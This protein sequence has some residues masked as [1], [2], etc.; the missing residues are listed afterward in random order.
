MQNF[1]DIRE[2]LESTEYH[3]LKA[4]FE[5]LG[6]GDVFHGGTKKKTLIDKAIEALELKEEQDQD[7]EEDLEQEQEFIDTESEQETSD[8]EETPEPVLKQTATQSKEAVRKTKKSKLTRDQ[9]L[10]N[11]EN[12]KLN[13]ISAQGAAKTKLIEKRRELESML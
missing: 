6:V 7:P 3:E 8:P 13:L 5:E 1:E 12:I 9:I 11:L 10:D 2:M 4:K